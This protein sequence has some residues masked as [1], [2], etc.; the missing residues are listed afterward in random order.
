[1]RA[2]RFLLMSV[3]VLAQSIAFGLPAAEN[4]QQEAE[5]IK[6]AVRA[7]E[8]QIRQIEGAPT[9]EQEK[10][11]ALAE[12]MESMLKDADRLHPEE[13]A[14]ILAIDARLRAVAPA[15]SR[16]MAVAAAADHPDVQAEFAE[17]LSESGLGSFDHVPTHA[18]QQGDGTSPVDEIQMNTSLTSMAKRQSVWVFWSIDSKNDVLAAQLEAVGRKLP[19]VSRA[20]VHLMP[21]REWRSWAQVMGSFQ[22]RVAAIQ[23]GGDLVASHR[24]RLRQD[25][26]A[27]M[28]TTQGF[29]AMVASFR[30]GGYRI[31]DDMTAAEYFDIKR[32][33]TIV[34]VSSRGI[35]H[36]MD[37]CSVNES[38][39][40][41]I[42]RAEEWEAKQ[43]ASGR[44]FP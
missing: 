14:K 30:P 3:I 7:V 22:D 20:D 1:M 31:I 26:E 15:F 39:L 42:Q 36:R 43:V 33:P 34:Y 10:L 21:L 13:R 18:F 4:P 11:R 41:F 19:G 29:N 38:M 27:M 37:G 12:A 35:E 2:W 16:E 40:T 44:V 25:A 24:D 9:A 6:A 17:I 32:V 28:V 23:A 8:D 5:D